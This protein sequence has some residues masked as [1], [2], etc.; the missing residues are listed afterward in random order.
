LLFSQ[1]ASS[2]EKWS[3]MTEDLDQ[4][5]EEDEMDENE[6]HD[7]LFFVDAQ[8]SSELLERCQVRF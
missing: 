8:G 7:P 2:P 3:Q 4:K 6:T 1:L 5:N